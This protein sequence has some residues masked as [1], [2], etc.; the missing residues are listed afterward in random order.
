MADPDRSTALAGL[1]TRSTES[2]YWQLRAAG[3]MP[4]QQFLGAGAAAAELLDSGI[5]YRSGPDEGMVRSVEPATALRLVL[6]RRQHELVDRHE[7]VLAGWRRLTSLQPPAP[8]G[9]SGDRVDGIRLM[10]NA[11]EVMASAAELY[12]AP[13][14]RLRGT[15]TV[16]PAQRRRGPTR[17]CARYQLIY[18]SEH[19]D[20][21]GGAD[22]IRETAQAG[23]EVR[24]RDRLP[25]RMLH[26]DDSVALVGIGP[27]AMLV[28][29]DPILAMLAEWFDLLWADPSTVRWHEADAGQADTPDE[30]QSRV[31]RLMP[32][33]DDTAIARRL[34]ISVST[35]RRHIKALYLL[36]DVDNR[37]AAGMVAAKRGWL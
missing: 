21:K 1:V 29:S 18:D 34:G 32:T 28:R 5:A 8:A 33:D 14:R 19:L 27:T 30:M 9:S 10:T 37:F 11:D 24:L 16:G 7:R 35:V 2:L 4:V 17:A 3:T 25:I 23:E 26:V 20:T 12:A 31:L 22:L 36:L 6:H 15:A 13:L